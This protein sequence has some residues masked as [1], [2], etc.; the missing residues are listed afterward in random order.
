MTFKEKYGPVALVAGASEGLGEAFAR[1]LAGQGFD[2][3]L[4]ARGKEQLHKV[5]AELSAQ[6]NIHTWPVVC[7]L[8][9][10]DAVSQI[11][12]QIGDLKIHF[13]VFNAAVSYI[14]PFLETTVEQHE[15][16][17]AVNN[18][19]MLRTVYAFAGPM[20]AEGRG[21][22]LLM[23]SLAGLQGS[24]FLVS[25]AASKAFIKILAEGL[26]YEWKPKGV[27]VL[28]CCAGAI[29]T[30]RYLKTSPREM[31]F[32]APRPQKAAKVVE[33]CLRKIGTGPSF[34][35]GRENRVAS[36][37]MQRIFSRKKAVNTMGNATCRIYDL[38]R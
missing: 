21:A 31:G 27:D 18:L 37:F 26:W 12:S 20:L 1:A 25:Y 5:S 4:V 35:S 33:E 2:L 36:F 22:I 23:S 28:A 19:G 9:S 7:D 14:G 6:Y 38:K 17:V 34:I 8:G 16:V 30:P 32:P 15:Q 13:L 24:G 29:A 10:A 3:V 11:R